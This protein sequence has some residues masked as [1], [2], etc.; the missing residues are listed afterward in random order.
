MRASKR[1][2]KN[3]PSHFTYRK[4]VMSN[5]LWWLLLLFL[6]K[7]LNEI[8]AYFSFFSHFFCRFLFFLQ[9][10]FLFYNEDWASIS[11][12]LRFSFDET[13]TVNE[14]KKTFAHTHTIARAEAKTEFLIK[15]KPGQ[16]KNTINIKKGFSLRMWRCHLCTQF[17]I[18]SII[19]MK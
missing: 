4:H 5:L 15:R 3:M 2:E 9:T 6:L 1:R 14:S 17:K 19:K 13:T 7:W 10:V 11:L 8:S 18:Y 12:P 16:R